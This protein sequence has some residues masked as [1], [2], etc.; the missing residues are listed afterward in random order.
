MGWTCSSYEKKCSLR[1]ETPHSFPV[2]E[3]HSTQSTRKA[4]RIMEFKHMEC[5]TVYDKPPVA[6]LVKNFATSHTVFMFETCTKCGAIDPTHSQTNLLQPTAVFTLHNLHLIT[7]PPTPP[8]IPL[9][10]RVIT[11]GGASI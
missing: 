9:N 10:I 2:T 8:G 6:Q 4:L 5:G 1:Y 11:T 7:H 3:S